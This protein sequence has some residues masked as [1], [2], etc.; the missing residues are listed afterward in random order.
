MRKTQTKVVCAFGPSYLSP[1]V[2]DQLDLMV[3]REV[4]SEFH[5]SEVK[6]MK[7][8]HVCAQ[9][10][11]AARGIGAVETDGLAL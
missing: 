1:Y 2:V 4:V 6:V 5:V 11:R 3:V 9:L 10:V 7:L 8:G